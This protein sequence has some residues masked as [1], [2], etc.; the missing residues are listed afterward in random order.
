MQSLT[1]FVKR[2]ILDVWQDSEYVSESKEKM[3]L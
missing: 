2:S 3:T 1:I